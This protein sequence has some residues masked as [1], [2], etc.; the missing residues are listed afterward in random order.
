[1][2]FVSNDLNFNTRSFIDGWG[3][4]LSFLGGHFQPCG[5]VFNL[6]KCYHQGCLYNHIFPNLGSCAACSAH[7][8]CH[9]ELW[10]TSMS[11]P[12]SFPF[13]AI[14]LFPYGWFV[15]AVFGAITVK[16]ISLREKVH[17]YKVALSKNI[18]TL[19]GTSFLCYFFIVLF[20]YFN[21]NLWICVLYMRGKSMTPI[22]SVKNTSM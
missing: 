14:L 13:C 17:R 1:M 18:C 7:S 19:C 21:C 22:E 9:N 2:Y 5:R 20:S 3:L 15:I 16:G 4:G 10:L 6:C 8:M 12:F 11:Y